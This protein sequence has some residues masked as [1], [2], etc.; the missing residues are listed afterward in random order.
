MSRSPMKTEPTV[1]SS[2]P[3]TIR[4]VVV[5]PQPDGPSRAKN[6]PFGTVRVRSSTA[7]NVP[8]SLVTSTSLRSSPELVRWLLRRE[9][10]HVVSPSS[11]VRTTVCTASPGCR[12]T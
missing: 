9:V 12:A 4:S 7:L 2:S 5:L 3:A 8:K 1:G 6:D 10:C 11:F